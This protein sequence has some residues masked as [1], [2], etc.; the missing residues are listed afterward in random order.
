MA[1]KFALL[2]GVPRGAT[3]V[4]RLGMRYESQA[5]KARPTCFTYRTKRA[6]YGRTCEL[7][8]A[9]LE[10]LLVKLLGLWKGLMGSI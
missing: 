10:R 9:V 5:G 1:I 6:T 8:R 7:T 4:P 2:E 3:G